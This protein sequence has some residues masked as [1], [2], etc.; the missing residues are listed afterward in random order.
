MVELAQE[1]LRLDTAQTVEETRSSHALAGSRMDYAELSTVYV[2]AFAPETSFTLPSSLLAE[3]DAAIQ[4][5]GNAGAQGTIDIFDPPSL[6]LY[7]ESHLRSG[8]THPH[9]PNDYSLS[10]LGTSLLAVSIA[11]A[12]PQISRD[13]QKPNRL[14]DPQKG[15]PNGYS[16]DYRVPRGG[17][18]HQ[19]P[20]FSLES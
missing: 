11:T 9:L 14:Y 15:Y 7:S 20:P 5:T 6:P 1:S 19:V 16:P 17:P 10:V 8:T 3:F 13:W 4:A 18:L 2:L 12:C